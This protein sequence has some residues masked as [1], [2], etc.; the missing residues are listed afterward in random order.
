MKKF[1]LSA[2]VVLLI[3]FAFAPYINGLVLEKIITQYQEDVNAMNAETG[4]DVRIEIMAIDRNFSSSE[5]DWR[6]DLGS[7]AEVYGVEEIILVDRAEHGFTGVVSRTS[8]EKNPWFADLV[9]RKLD[10]KNPLTITTIYPLAGSIESIIELDAFTFAMEEETVTF[11]PAK[12]VTEFD[13]E[14]NRFVSEAGWEGLSVTDKMTIADLAITYDL[15]QISTYTWAGRIS[16]RLENLEAV[17][18]DQRVKIAHLQGEYSLEFD[19][20]NNRLSMTGGVEIDTILTHEEQLADMLLRMEINNIDATGYEEFMESYTRTMHAM[21]DEAAAAKD[22]PEKMNQAMQAKMTSYSLNMIA[23]YEKLLK[24]GL[25]FNITD[26]RARIPE[27]NI[28]GN[29][30]LQLK[31]DLT[32]AQLT[33]V[34]M[35]PQLAFDY[36]FLQSNFRFPAEIAGDNQML[37]SPVYQ[38]MQTGLFVLEGSDM[39]HSAQTLDGRLLLNGREVL[40]QGMMQ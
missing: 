20:D 37:V 10:G 33:P 40:F 39:V 21:L 27:G 1:V 17:D 28:T 9:N 30:Q 25:E 19:E 36:F 4:S 8:L 5:I 29:M 14:L 3:A 6:I 34:I 18:K 38:G 31:R 11:R 13:R 26:L 16:F 2:V 22:N 12:V 15:E 7:L 23:A 32:F 24:K 35:Q